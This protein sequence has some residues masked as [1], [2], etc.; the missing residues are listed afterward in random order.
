[1]VRLTTLNAG[2][3]FKYNNEVY[4]KVHNREKSGKV[5]KLSDSTE[6]RLPV[7][8][9]VDKVREEDLPKKKKKAVAHE[10]V[11]LPF[12]EKVELVLP[13]VSG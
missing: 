6:C 5:I 9:M 11:E 7:M 13:A 10:Q 4:R 2:E 8:L 12:P 1:M 3:L